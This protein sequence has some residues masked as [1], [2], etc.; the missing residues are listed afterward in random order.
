VEDTIIKS[1]IKEKNRQNLL[2]EHLE[3]KADEEK[4]DT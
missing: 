1:P 3:A 2:E 4:K